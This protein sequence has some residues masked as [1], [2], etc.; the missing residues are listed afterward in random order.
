MN[1]IRNTPIDVASTRILHYLRIHNY[2][3]CA[4]YINRLNSITF[5]KILINDLPLDILLSQLPFSIEIFGFDFRNSV[6]KS[7]LLS[8]L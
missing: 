5:R 1:S 2:D 8:I 7:N 6:I 3:D 4:I